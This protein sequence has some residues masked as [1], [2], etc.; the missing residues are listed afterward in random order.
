MG[1]SSSTVYLVIGLAVV[2]AN[3]PF[4][5]SRLLM[6]KTLGQRKHVGWQVLELLLYYLVAGAVAV[7]LE[8]QAGQRSPQGWEFYAITLA[9]FLTLAFPGFV[10]AHLWKSHR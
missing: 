9:L 8:A 1:S 6:V 4:V 10:Y 5:S 7:A 2:L 3:L